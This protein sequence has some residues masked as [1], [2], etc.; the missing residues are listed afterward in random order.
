VIEEAGAL[1][2]GG[3]VVSGNLAVNAL[4]ARRGLRLHTVVSCGNAVAVEPADWVLHLSG[5]EEVGSIA[6]YMEAEGDGERLCEALAGCIDTGVGVA[7]LKAGGSA[8]GCAA[9]AAHTGAVAGDQRVFRA[10]VDE[11]GAA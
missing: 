6:L 1:G 11:A 4:T 2:C 10:L 7:V 3:A 8:A 5:E 9:A